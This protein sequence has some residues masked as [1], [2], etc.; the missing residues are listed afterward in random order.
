MYEFSREE[1]NR[2][3]RILPTLKSGMITAV[4][5]DTHTYE[6]QTSEGG[7]IEGRP[8]LTEGGGLI[9]GQGTA[10]LFDIGAQV[11]YYHDINNGIILG[12][13]PPPGI[14]TPH[15]PPIT[16]ANVTSSTETP[17]GPDLSYRSGAPPDL[18]P[19]DWVKY[20]AESGFIALLRGAIATMGAGPMAGIEF[21]SVDDTGKINARNLHINT[22]FMEVESNNDEGEVNL[23][24][25]AAPNY[26]ETVGADKPGQ[27]FGEHAE[28][29]D[30]LRYTAES[31]D[32]MGKWR[33]HAFAG[34][35]GDNLHL[36]ISKRGDADRRS[37][38]TPPV[39]LTEIVLSHDGAVR[40]RSCRELMLE[41]V[42][43]IHVPKKVREA[44]HNEF[45]DSKDKGNY[46]PSDHQ[47]YE[48]DKDNPEGRRMQ[49]TGYHSHTVDHEEIRHF[50]DHKNDWNV[51]SERTAEIPTPAQDSPGGRSEDEFEETYSVIHQRSDGSI[52][53]E[54]N[55][56]SIVDMNKEDISFSAKRDLKLQAG[57]DVLITGAR[58]GAIRTQED[59]NIV[60]HNGHTRVKAHKD[61]RL[62]AENNASLDSKVNTAVIA[63]TGETLIR[64][65]RA[66][67][68]LK[69][70]RAAIQAVAVNGNLDFR[71]SGAISIVSDSSSVGI[72]GS[73]QA[74]ITSGG[75][76]LAA[77][78]IESPAPSMESN[79]R[80]S[81][82]YTNTTLSIDNGNQVQV[83]NLQDFSYLELAG[84]SAKIHGASAMDV[85]GDNLINVFVE[86]AKLRLARNTVQLTSAGANTIV[87]EGGLQLN[88]TDDDTDEQG[89]DNIWTPGAGHF[90]PTRADPAADLVTTV[91]ADV[92]AEN[93]ADGRFRYA[94][95]PKD[96][97]KV[98]QYPWQNMDPQSGTPGLTNWADIIPTAEQDVPDVG[99][100]RPVNGD[101]QG[102]GGTTTGDEER[103]LPYGR[104]FEYTYDSFSWDDGVKPG[105]FSETGQ[106]L[107]PDTS[108]TTTTTDDSAVGRVNLIPD[109]AK[110]ESFQG[111][112]EENSKENP[113]NEPLVDS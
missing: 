11:I 72:H 36:F 17:E 15:N 2:L 27:E 104:Y 58:E 79:I 75:R 46:N 67:V 64:S 40:V 6:I 8:A 34:W 1:L 51:Q 73:A 3:A 107:V 92:Q 81:G 4:Y 44:Y 96:D 56:G 38:V 21:N 50:R 23:Q 43:R 70:D 65:E 20:N 99:P 62:Y 86:G 10:A 103:M 69:S 91:A 71:A 93:Y 31:A 53:L 68:V 45:G 47:F 18:L 98:Y 83:T 97:H 12:S 88:Q 48:W 66:N 60:S 39:G 106:F 63:R 94:D 77:T 89:P 25:F 78:G 32:R 42:S 35:L 76:V 57:R 33:I 101:S 95:E 52:Y 84:P 108:G 54:D 80:N 110:G 59:I 74:Q 26:F 22:D 29:G 55:W 90:D 85:T 112:T 16:Y 37:D 102:G 105:Q 7:F 100:H 13:V 82:A 9:R 111:S 109:S 61:L 24:V 19:G 28:G 49:E 113:A 5:P 14:P 41:K 87:K 30:K